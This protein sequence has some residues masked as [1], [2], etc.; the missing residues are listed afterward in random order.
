[1]EV[2][3]DLIGTGVFFLIDID[4]T[5]RRLFV[6]VRH[7]PFGDTPV[8]EGWWGVGCGVTGGLH[9]IDVQDHNFT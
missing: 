1:M 6:G 3:G 5:R 2:G 4:K 7:H 8:L 9:C